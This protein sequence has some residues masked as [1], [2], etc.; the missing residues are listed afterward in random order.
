MK[1]A[2]W[3]VD[4]ITLS[5]P[6]VDRREAVEVI[7]AGLEEGLGR[8]LASIRLPPMPGGA[9]ELAFEKRVSRAKKMTRDRKRMEFEDRMDFVASLWNAQSMLD[10]ETLDSSSTSVG[11]ALGDVNSPALTGMSRPDL[12]SVS[13][14][15]LQAESENSQPP[16]LTETLRWSDIPP[17]VT[18]K[19]LES[20][21]AVRHE[22]ASPVELWIDSPF[23]RLI[24]SKPQ[25]RKLGDLARDLLKN[26]AAEWSMIRG[27][28]LRLWEDVEEPDWRVN[29]I[30][31]FVGPSPFSTRLELW[32][33]ADRR[34]SQLALRELKQLR[35]VAARQFRDLIGNT[36]IQV[37]LQEG[38]T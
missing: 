31:L 22:R 10:G 14:M 18:R 20:I 19:D 36:F 33:E 11:G 25:A 9:R 24:R 28:K 13:P 5:H 7:I 1:L 37:N 29:Q 38:E 23:K 35:G 21:I 15:R 32:E 30:E 16:L 6:D 8:A 27:G 26:L 4:Q 34:F 2:E 17:R 3:L 12:P